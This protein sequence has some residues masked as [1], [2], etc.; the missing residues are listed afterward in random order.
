MIQHFQQ[1]QPNGFLEIHGGVLF[2]K[3]IF[4]SSTWLYPAANQGMFFCLILGA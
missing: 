3:G 2:V 1:I 4:L